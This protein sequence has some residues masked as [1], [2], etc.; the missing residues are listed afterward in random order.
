MAEE[1]SGILV[2][3][4]A[5]DHRRLLRLLGSLTEHLGRLPDP[6]GGTSYARGSDLVAAALLVAERD[7]EVLAAVGTE[8]RRRRLR[9]AARSE[10][11]GVCDALGGIVPRLEHDEARQDG[12]HLIR[13]LREV[14]VAVAVRDEP[15][16]TAHTLGR[17]ARRLADLAQR[18]GPWAQSL[19]DLAGLLDDVQDALHP[20]A[21]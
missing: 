8:I 15:V 16:A 11:L 14:A 9:R 17:E 4:G 13:A 20:R 2:P 6:E 21:D 12:E 3:I 5:E 10:L 7:P 19:Q 18:A 1:P